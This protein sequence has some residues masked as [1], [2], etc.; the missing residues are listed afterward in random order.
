MLLSRAAM[1]NFVITHNRIA[2]RWDHK[3]HENCCGDWVLAQV[4]KEYGMDVMNSWPTINGEK[5][6]MILFASDHC[7]QPLVTMHHISPAEAQ[8]LGKF[9]TEKAQ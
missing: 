3:L 1:R 9:R 2:A 6:S 5:P 7:C 4:L 8:R